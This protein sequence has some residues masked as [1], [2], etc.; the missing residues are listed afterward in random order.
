MSVHR[1]SQRA[2]FGIVQWRCAARS[3]SVLSRSSVA[4]A[5]R[6]KAHIFETTPIGHRPLPSLLCKTISTDKRGSLIYTG[7]LSKAVRSIKIFSISTAICSLTFGPILI[8]LGNPATP[9]IGRVAIASLV[10]TVG[11]S[12]TFILHWFIKS[13]VTKLYYDQDKGNVTIETLSLFGRSKVTQFHISDAKPPGAVTAFSTF[14]GAGKHFFL[15][16]ELFE[17]PALLR[18]LLGNFS[19]FEDTLK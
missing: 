19:T 17:D 14:Q 1:I 6:I 16:T 8:F 15:H 10:T 2:I 3:F 13:Y 18:Q 7:P 11:L 9:I 5:V 12:T 4:G